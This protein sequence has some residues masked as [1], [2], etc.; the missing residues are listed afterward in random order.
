[1]ENFIFISFYALL[2]IG[3]R[4]ESLSGFED[5]SCYSPVLTGGGEPETE[6]TC[7]LSP[8]LAVLCSIPAYV[9]QPFCKCE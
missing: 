4:Y 6:E 9:S 1:M 8:G 2:G 7:T 3:L 5:S